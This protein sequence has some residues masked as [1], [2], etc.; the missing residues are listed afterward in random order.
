MADHIYDERR[1]KLRVAILTV[2]NRVSGRTL[3]EN[4]L[5][6]DMNL[7]LEPRAEVPE[8]RDELI[9]LRDMGLI[10]IVAPGRLYSERKVMITDEGR[11]AL[12]E[13]Q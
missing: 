11:L 5:Y 4:I 3:S 9:A 2:L 1:A 7:H 8:F 12:A 10:V 6:A 13:V